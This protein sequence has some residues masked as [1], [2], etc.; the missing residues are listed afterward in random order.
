MTNIFLFKMV[1]NYIYI[2]RITDHVKQMCTVKQLHYSKTLHILMIKMTN[3][4]QFTN[5]LKWVSCFEI[6]NQLWHLHNSVIW[7]NKSRNKVAGAVPKPL[8][9]V[10]FLCYSK[11]WKCSGWVI[12]I[13][14]SGIA[15]SRGS[16]HSKL[17]GV[18]VVVLCYLKL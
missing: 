16:A 5:T 15:I 13:Q 10:L 8:L 3:K 4:I 9:V 2:T 14:K 6:T 12:V 18:V 17:T 1:N 7:D 11:L